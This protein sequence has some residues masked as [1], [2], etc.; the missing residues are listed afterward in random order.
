MAIL[1]VYLF[2]KGIVCVCMSLRNAKQ[3]KKVHVDFIISLS[4]HMQASGVSYRFNIS[5]PA[6]CTPYTSTCTFYAALRTN[7]NSSA[8][9]DYYMEGAATGYLALGWNNISQTVSKYQIIT[10]KNFLN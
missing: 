9:L 10:A 7:V 3:K 8:W 1:Y 5:I 2:L 6:G 4:R